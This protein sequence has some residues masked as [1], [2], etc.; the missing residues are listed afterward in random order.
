MKLAELQ[1]RFGHAL[2]HGNDAALTDWLRDDGI[3][4]KALL[5]I[6]RDSV[7][8][9]V[10]SVLRD[11]FAAVCWLFGDEKFRW[12]AEAF[13][14]AYPPTKPCLDEYGECFAEFLAGSDAALGR[15]YLPDLARLEWLIHQAVHP[16]ESVVSS[17]SALRRAARA[18]PMRLIVRLDPS[19]GW[20]KSRFPV[21][22]IWS[23]S[24]R[25]SAIQDLGRKRRNI[26][27]E[28][29]R[30][31]GQ[32]VPRRLDEADH[33]FRSA[34]GSGASLAAAGEAAKI[35]KPDFAVLQALDELLRADAVVSLSIRRS[36][37]KIWPGSQPQRP[38]KVASGSAID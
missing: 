38:A 37:R 18:D 21:D 1:A 27:I 36:A 15:P 14:R 19:M 34:I 12:A 22:K 17:A 20:V 30:R 2:L 33:A 4:P 10:T 25:K 11:T 35:L 29:R 9:S 5:D 16:P 24:L 8:A 31:M 32:V 28:V 26:Y 13:V 7:F 3:P 23:G 6:Y